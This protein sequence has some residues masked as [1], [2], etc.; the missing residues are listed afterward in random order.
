MNARVVLRDQGFDPEF[1]DWAKAKVLAAFS[2][3]GDEIARVQ[4][5]A[6]DVN[7]PRGGDDKRCALRLQTRLFGQLSFDSVDAE[8]RRAVARVIR[9]ARRFIQRSLSVR[10]SHRRSGPTAD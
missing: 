3:Y 1:A 7:G 10:R 9:R 6:S 2:R 8:P 5:T 4:I